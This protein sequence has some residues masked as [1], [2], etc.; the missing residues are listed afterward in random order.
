[1]NRAG[2]AFAGG[3]SLL[4]A[5]NACTSGSSEPTYD[6]GEFE[7][8]VF[9]CSDIE[10]P[11]FPESLELAGGWESDQTVR[12]DDHPAL[13]GDDSA[14][15]KSLH[16]IKCE[17]SHAESELQLRLS[18][19]YYPSEESAADWFEGNLISSSADYLSTE[20]DDDAEGEETSWDGIAFKEINEYE[21]RSNFLLSNL[22]LSVLIY[23]PDNELENLPKPTMEIAEDI[24][25]EAA[26]FA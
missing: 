20:P 21:A 6:T 24:A 26:S 1:M 9:A 15:W 7:D 12:V 25:T 10:D 4:L 18:A 2:F 17:F 5:L 11:A 8:A 13:S 22:E 19:W 3:A 14:D 16:Q 23:Y